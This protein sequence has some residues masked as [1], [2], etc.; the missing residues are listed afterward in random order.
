MS[1]AQA[2]KIDP[3][4][5]NKPMYTVDEYF[6]GLEKDLVEEWALE[7]AMKHGITLEESKKRVE[8][9]MY[10]T[11]TREELEAHSM[12]LDEMHERLLKNIK[13]RFAERELNAETEAAKKEARE[14]NLKT[15]SSVDE[16]MN[17]IL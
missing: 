2:L 7:A 10:P 17:D 9:A 4:F 12:T 11:I 1:S 6:E 15:Y 14:S 8:Q 16:M 5:K 13:R 3:D